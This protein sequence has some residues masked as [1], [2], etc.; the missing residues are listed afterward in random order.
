MALSLTTPRSALRTINDSNVPLKNIQAL[1][2]GN[3]SLKNSEFQKPLASANPF[4]TFGDLTKSLPDCSKSK[5]KIHVDPA[6]SRVKTKEEVKVITRAPEPLPEIETLHVFNPD[7]EIKP[8]VEEVGESLLRKIRR[9]G[10]PCLAARGDLDSGDE[11]D[12]VVDVKN[13]DPDME[14]LDRLDALDPFMMVGDSDFDRVPEAEISLPSMDE[15]PGIEDLPL[16]YL[17]DS[18]DIEPNMGTLEV[19][20]SFNSLDHSPA[21][22]GARGSESDRSMND[23]SMSP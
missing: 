15:I 4:K 11:D 12:D 9:W 7:A 16:P 6:P 2:G 22:K 5:L 1:K 13:F 18:I 20:G 23:S 17:D 3:T 14:Q 19:W 21:G 8:M 10:M